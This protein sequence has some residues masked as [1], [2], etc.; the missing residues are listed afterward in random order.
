MRFRSLLAAILALL[1]TSVPA[2]AAA[3]QWHDET[4]DPLPSGQSGVFD[5]LYA[6]SDGTA[7]AVGHRYGV[8]GGALEFRTWVQRYNGI[9]WHRVNSEDT[10]GAP[11]GNTLIGVDGSSP[12]DVWA[13]GSWWVA[14]R[15]HSLIER[16][17]GSAFTMVQT[18]DST[19]G[20]SLSGV[21]ALSTTNVWAVGTA[22]QPGIDYG[23]SAL[24]WNGKAWK[25]VDVPMPDGCTSR[26]ELYDVVAAAPGLVYAVG[27]L[28]DR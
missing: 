25:R 16:W 26:V 22:L 8:V 1:L 23:G 20:E 17:N 3:G 14:G 15:T 6:A 13:V 5:G 27:D 4:I 2:A 28:Q 24:H 18:P 11:A 7:F 9:D 21:S 12:T 19:Y 10:E